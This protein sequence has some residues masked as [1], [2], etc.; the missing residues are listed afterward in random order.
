LGNTK[1]AARKKE[2]H[3]RGSE[4]Y[5]NQFSPTRRLENLGPGFPREPASKKN[6]QNSKGSTATDDG[7]TGMCLRGRSAA[8]K[9]SRAE[10]LISQQATFFGGCV[11]DSLNSR[12]K[13][14]CRFWIFLLNKLQLGSLPERF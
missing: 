11:V 3:L 8:A 9:G 12:L 1:I 6:L 10:Q 7:L 2:V 13:L 5:D 4:G 14:E